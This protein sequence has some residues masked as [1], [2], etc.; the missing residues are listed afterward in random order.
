[1]LNI[2]T[3]SV[4]TQS[5]TSAFIGVQPGVYRLVLEQ[6]GAFSR[7]DVT[8]LA[9]F[10]AEVDREIEP[11]DTPARF[12]ELYPG[13]AMKGSSN[14]Y[15][16]STETDE[17]WYLFR[18]P[19][20]GYANYTLIHE[21]M[22]M[23]SVSWQIYL[24][25]AALNQLSFNNADFSEGS[26]TGE[27]VGLGEGLYFICVKGRVHSTQDYAIKVDT[28]E[29]VLFEQESND[30]FETA[31]PVSAGAVF[32]GMMN[33][34]SQGIDYDYYAVTLTKPGSLK[35]I[36]RHAAIDEDEDGEVYIGWNISLFNAEGE[37]LYSGSSD[38]KDTV[39]LSP[40]MGVAADTYYVCIDSDNRYF[41]PEPYIVQIEHASDRSFE[42]E[43][44]NTSD[45]A[46][47]A[48]FG[49]AVKGSL[50]QAGLETDCDWFVYSIASDMDVRLTFSHEKV[51]LDRL[52]W[53]VT[54]TDVDG[55]VYTPMDE[56]GL[57]FTDA[58]GAV[59]NQVPVNWNQSDATACFRLKAGDYYVRI[60]AGDYFSSETYSLL[61]QKK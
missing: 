56:K 33:N 47:Q 44:N 23:I 8:V 16:T 12:T 52:G 53:I 37:K 57:P 20:D 38:W 40:E 27:Q 36:F 54:L 10:T 46:S 43:P 1:M 9:D 6:S 51:N 28:V 61:L 17:D 14:K 41:S 29:A 11:N 15:E 45:K 32:N 7:D 18:M 13:Y 31:T 21:A 3:S 34:R 35:I 42:A 5:V 26:I 19:Y 48:V 55:N 25:D 24:Y 49:N 60:D 59:I 39:N 50:T 58:A 22:D 30:T 4:A 2:L